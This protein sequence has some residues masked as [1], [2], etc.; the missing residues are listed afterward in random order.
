MG[1]SV[2]PWQGLRVVGRGAEI[3]DHEKLAD[4]PADAE[5][6]DAQP[7]PQR[8]PMPTQSSILVRSGDSAPRS[9]SFQDNTGR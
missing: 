1:V 8:I 5:G 3:L 6:V 9:M 4:R 2:E 7:D